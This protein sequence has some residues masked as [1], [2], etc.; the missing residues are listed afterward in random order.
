MLAEENAVEIDHAAISLRQS[1]KCRSKS[2]DIFF[3]DEGEATELTTAELNVL[4]KSAPFYK[5][6][7]TGGPCGGKTTALARLSSYLRERGF[8]VFTVPEG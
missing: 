1:L 6:V 2:V 5:L 3:S 7:L 4:Q 8:E